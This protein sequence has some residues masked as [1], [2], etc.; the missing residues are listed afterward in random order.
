MEG[1]LGFEPRTIAS[2]AIVVTLN[3]AT[4]YN[5]IKREY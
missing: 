4:Y 1:K 2:N 5:M 3:R